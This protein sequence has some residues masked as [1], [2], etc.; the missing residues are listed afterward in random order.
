MAARVF[1]VGLKLPGDA[2][3]YVPFRSQQSLFDADVIIFY[4][5]LDGYSAHESS[6]RVLPDLSP[7]S[8]M[9]PRHLH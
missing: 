6:W 1:T 8:L 3:E 7:T 5:T 2:G 4:P 9:T